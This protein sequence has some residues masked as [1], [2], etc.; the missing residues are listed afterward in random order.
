MNE[1]DRKERE[2]QLKMQMKKK[3]FDEKVKLME[4]QQRIE[5]TAWG[6]WCV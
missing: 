4:L 6:V 1:E 3:E 2:R 5:G